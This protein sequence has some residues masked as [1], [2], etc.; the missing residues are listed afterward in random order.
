MILQIEGASRWMYIPVEPMA[1]EIIE[2]YVEQQKYS[3]FLVLI[4][5]IFFVLIVSLILFVWSL[6]FEC[7]L[8][9]N[10]AYV[11]G[12]RAR[13]RK[14]DLC[15]FRLFLVLAIL[16]YGPSSGFLFYNYHALS[17]Y[18]AS[19]EHVS[20][21]LKYSYPSTRTWDKIQLW[22]ECCG[23]NSYKYWVDKWEMNAVPDSCCKTQLYAQGC[24][25]FKKL[26]QINTNGCLPNVTDYINSRMRYHTKNK[27]IF[28][29]LCGTAMAIGCIMIIHLTRKEYY[30]E[31]SCFK[32]RANVMDRN[33]DQ[34]VVVNNDVEENVDENPGNN[35][36]NG[37][38]I[39]NMDVEDNVIV[40]VD[41]DEHLIQ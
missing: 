6:G 25:H 35:N 19:K 30:G 10:V 24:G 38:G 8:C 20:E 29:L 31:F 27:Q 15:R 23:L 12:Q 13:E 1:W 18:E 3:N 37:N 40:H 4:I 16:I 2:T 34:V 36:V 39:V 33:D 11:R 17:H 22:F 28:A 26:D 32:T 21:Y 14:R 5:W 41:E 7:C 9:F